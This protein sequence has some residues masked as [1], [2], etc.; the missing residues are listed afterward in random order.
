MIEREPH[1]NDWRPNRGPQERFLSLS[2]FEAL[3]GGA[4]G[5][6]KAPPSS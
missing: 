3:Y 5:G 1:P 4:A 6:G 2:C